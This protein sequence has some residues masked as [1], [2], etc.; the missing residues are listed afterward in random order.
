M[1]GEPRWMPA[2]SRGVNVDLR[3]ET[4]SLKCARTDYKNGSHAGIRG[5]G[6]YRK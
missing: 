2:I 4:G 5:G 1:P 6:V 3:T